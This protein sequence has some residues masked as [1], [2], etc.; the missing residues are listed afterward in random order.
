[1]G[2]TEVIMVAFAEDNSSNRP[3]KIRKKIHTDPCGS[4]ARPKVPAFLSCVTW[5][6][7]N[8]G[9]IDQNRPKEC[10]EEF[11]QKVGQNNT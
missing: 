10:P 4:L 11:A 7:K 6:P 3:R 8:E 5:F 1:M 9:K 2:K